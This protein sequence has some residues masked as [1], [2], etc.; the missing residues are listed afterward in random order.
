[1]FTTTT[2]K[3]IT[4]RSTHEMHLYFY[5]ILE[6]ITDDEIE[7]WNKVYEVSF[8]P[9]SEFFQTSNGENYRTFFQ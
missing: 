5:V 7:L 4:I 2:I 8:K 1:M 6:V 9:N 3:G